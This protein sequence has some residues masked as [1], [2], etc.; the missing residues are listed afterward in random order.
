MIKRT[1]IHLDEAETVVAPDG[2]TVRPLVEMEGGSFAEFSLPA[3]NV[4]QPI[5]HKTIEEIWHVVSGEGEI[6]REGINQ[7]DPLPLSE[8][9]CVAIPPR[10]A[11]QIKAG[12]KE[13]V[14]LAVTMPPWPGDHEV[15]V[16]SDLGPWMPT[17]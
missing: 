10:T 6:W 8:G 2:L 14:V 1:E 16:V 11:F 9:Q 5:R 12:A 7:G 13:L 15:E 3:G 17:A 4:G